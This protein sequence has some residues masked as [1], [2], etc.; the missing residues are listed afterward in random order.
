MNQR[1]YL[2]FDKSAA[3]SPIL[4]SLTARYGVVFNIFGATVNETE[5]T[6][7]LELEGSREN[8]EAAISYLQQHHGV[9]LCPHL[10]NRPP[11]DETFY[12]TLQLSYH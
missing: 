1:L 6:I 8:L 11:L 12:E 9:S 5:Q 2:T 4:S 7:A 10:G 3:Q